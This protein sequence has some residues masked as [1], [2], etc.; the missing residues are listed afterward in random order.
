VTINAARITALA[1]FTACTL[2]LRARAETRYE[3]EHYFPRRTFDLIAHGGV[4]VAQSKSNDPGLVVSGTGFLRLSS[5]WGGPTI[6]LD[7][8]RRSLRTGG[9]KTDGLLYLSHRIALTRL[10]R[11]EPWLEPIGIG[12]GFYRPAVGID[13]FVAPDVRFGCAAKVPIF[14]SPT[15]DLLDVGV[16]LTAG[17]TVQLGPSVERGT[18][19]E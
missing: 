15:K 12:L 10:A 16:E 14:F 7:V 5:T 13:V 19:R 18:H 9:T 17:L 6:A 3:R 8:V 4:A 1:A 11:V 2:P